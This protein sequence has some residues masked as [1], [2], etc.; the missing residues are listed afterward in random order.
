M[1]PLSKAATS[2][3]A[4]ADRV[5]SIF[6]RLTLFNR[7]MRPMW[8]MAASSLCDGDRTISPMGPTGDGM[9]RTC[10]MAGP[11]HSTSIN[12]SSNRSRGDR[13]I[14]DRLIRDRQSK[15]SQ[16]LRRNIADDVGDGDFA[17]DINGSDHKPGEGE[18]HRQH[19]DHDLPGI[20][21]FR[22]CR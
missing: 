9:G 22:H 8:Y 2:G 11:E 16:L 17:V 20:R 4:S 5:I 13:L 12:A 15:G 14:R 1:S 10:P 19:V 21:K 18:A 7:P 3:G 6:C